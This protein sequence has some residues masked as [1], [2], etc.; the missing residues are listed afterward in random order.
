MGALDG[1]I[2]VCGECRS[3][4]NEGA[5]Q[6]YNCRTPRDRAAVDPATIDPSSHG[7]LREIAL[8]A[9]HSPRPFA[10]LAS[11]LIL[12]TAG[13]QVVY[14]LDFSS[15]LLQ[16]LGGT[17]ATDVQLQFMGTIGLVTVGISIL[18][19]VAWSLWLSRAVTAMPALGLGYPA[20][21]GLTAFVEN[22]LP[23]LNL[24]RVP[25][26]VR[27]VVRRVEPGSYRGEALIFAAWIG[28]LGGFVVP[29]VFGLLN[30]LTA[31]TEDA[32][33]RTQLTVQ[34]V[35]IG[36]VLVGAVFLVW[37]IW[38]IE[39]RISRRRQAQ[40]AAI[41][42]AA[43]GGTDE[44]AETNE[45]GVEVRYLTPRVRE[46]APSTPGWMWK[47]TSDSLLAATGE[48]GDAASM[49]SGPGWDPEPPII[50]I[51]MPPQVPVAPS[52][53]V[54]VA[55][56]PPF[57]V[58]EP[59]PA[60][61]AGPSPAPVAAP[62]SALVTEPQPVD[63]PPPIA[64][65]EPPRVDVPITV[66]DVSVPAAGPVDDG[67]PHLTIRV[68]GHG[69]LQ[70]ELNGEQEPVILEDLAAYGSALANV[71]GTAEIVIAGSDDMARLIARRAQRIM[72]DAGIEATIPE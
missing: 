57:A 29:R 11:I 6:C 26:I 53:P 66:P 43:A 68:V 67:A 15:L 40:L 64:P 63:Q 18:A 37:L 3:I 16:T 19:L 14:T 22:F 7:K 42:V 21:T 32:A 58:A 24:L 44:P 2:W 47:D 10:V 33:L 31:E 46:S 70:A 51:P 28:L 45:E 13:M 1:N 25:A 20:A 34:G 23:G 54:P 72:A 59:P 9:F 60:P 61:V 65:P 49:Q 8:P 5:K 38:W 52:H 50:G 71:G 17:A 39:E 35:A 41:D 4:N 62:S 27:D 55:P 30:G 69:M 48:A 12:A 56:P 36:L